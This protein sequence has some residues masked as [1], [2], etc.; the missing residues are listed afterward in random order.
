MFRDNVRLPV[1]VSAKVPKTGCIGDL[2]RAVALLRPG[3]FVTDTPQPSL[4]LLEAEMVVCRVSMYSI[5]TL[6]IADEVEL[7]TVPDRDPLYIFQ[8]RR[9]RGRR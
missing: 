7:K 1:V 4:V 3:M 2:K 5:T 9:W 6:D 8:V